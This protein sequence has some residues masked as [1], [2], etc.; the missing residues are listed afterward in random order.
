MT[1][2][3]CKLATHNKRTCA[4]NTNTICSICNR[5]HSDKK[6]SFKRIYDSI[7]SLPKDL[8]YI[9]QSYKTESELYDSYKSYFS[10]VV[11]S[12]FKKTY[13]TTLYKEKYRNIR[14]YNFFMNVIIHN[15]K[16]LS[17]YLI[18]NNNTSDKKIKLFKL[19]DY[20]CE[21]KWLISPIRYYTE[22][23]KLIESV[24]STLYRL[25]IENTHTDINIL[26]LHYYM[27]LISKF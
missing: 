16:R 2:S 14:Y 3:I 15:I 6:C 22:I 1:C 19:L 4:I 12:E 26:N 7:P 9:I 25:I 18:N 27:S 11:L 24:H 21:F 5:G 17:R 10:N 13:E 20:I 23:N 8:I